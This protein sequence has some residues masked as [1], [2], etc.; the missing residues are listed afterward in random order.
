M[1]PRP[2]LG[3]LLGVLFIPGS[4]EGTLLEYETDGAADCLRVH[5][6][7]QVAASEVVEDAKAPLL[8]AVAEYLQEVR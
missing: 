4:G 7:G 3:I 1:F 2:V 5:G 6:C 8:T